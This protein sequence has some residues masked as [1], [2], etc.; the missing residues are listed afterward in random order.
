MKNFRTS[1]I[2]ISGLLCLLIIM[3]IQHKELQ[4]SSQGSAWLTN[5]T[6]QNGRYVLPTMTVQT[7][8]IAPKLLTG[9]W[10]IL[11]DYGFWP[12]ATFFIHKK[13][14]PS[15]AN[16]KVVIYLDDTELVQVPN[17]FG[18]SRYVYQRDH[19]I[20]KIQMVEGENHY[21]A[22]SPVLFKN[23]TFYFEGKD[24]SQ[25][26]IFFS[27]EMFKESE[28]VLNQTHDY[29]L[30]LNLGIEAHKRK[31]RVNGKFYEFFPW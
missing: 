14:V 5:Q 13:L 26:T 8:V 23:P 9:E 15:G 18:R 11:D 29:L 25:N 27:T 16:L 20:L 10:K 1:F 4:R 2:L 28:L 21:F 17:Y 12:D 6:N 30:N 7:E 31:T 3:D 22:R 19:G 24:S